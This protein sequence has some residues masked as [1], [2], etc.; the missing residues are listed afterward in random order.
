MPT[1]V[2]E[3]KKKKPK[4]QIENLQGS[5]LRLLLRANNSCQIIDSDIGRVA[6]L[7]FS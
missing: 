5:S 4:E 1:R 3:N 7:T 6:I 2:P